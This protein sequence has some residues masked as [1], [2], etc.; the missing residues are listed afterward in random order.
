M[1]INENLYQDPNGLVKK[2]ATVT[3]DDRFREWDSQ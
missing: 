3:I 1:S 2:C